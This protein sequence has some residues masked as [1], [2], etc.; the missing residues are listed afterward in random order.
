MITIKEFNEATSRYTK[1]V[2][3]MAAVSVTAMFGCFAIVLPF[4]DAVHGFYVA[5]FGDVAAELL[6]GM[7]PFPAVVVMF[8]G[9]WLVERQSKRD[10]PLHCPHCKK[11]L[12]GLQH[13]VIATR[14]CGY[15]GK[16][17][18]HDPTSCIL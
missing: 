8:V 16:P 1:R 15:C 10:G 18:L 13:L 11:C 9:I 6:L 3:R 17:V 4:R 2:L 5:Q 14:N 12:V 7:T